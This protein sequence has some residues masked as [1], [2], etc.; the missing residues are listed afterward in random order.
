MEAGRV[1]VAYLRRSQ[2]PPDGQTDLSW[3]VQEAAVR[4]LATQFGDGEN[5]LLLFDW[6]RTGRQGAA[7]RR[8]G[9][10]R[11]LEMLRT[12]QVSAIYSYS[13]SRLS[14]GV[15]D[16]LDIV[17]LASEVGV[18]IRL[19][20]EGPMDPET[21]VGKVQINIMSAL[22]QFELDLAADRARDAAAA[23][24]RQGKPVGAP[25]YGYRVRNGEVVANGD[26]TNALRL[27][28]ET[29]RETGS[30]QATARRLT[31]LGVPTRRG[32][33]FWG[34]TA[35]RQIVRREAPGLVPVTVARG[36]AGVGSFRLTGLLRC[37][38]GTVLTGRRF[39]GRYVSYVCKRGVVDPAHGRPVSISEGRVLPQVEKAV[40]RLHIDPN[41]EADLK[42][43]EAQARKR[44]DA[45][46]DSMLDGVVPR[47]EYARRRPEFEAAI[48]RAKRAIA[49]TLIDAQPID[50]DAS[51]VNRYLRGVFEAFD[52]DESYRAVMPVF[53]APEFMGSDQAHQVPTD[54]EGA[55]T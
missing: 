20:K 3:P 41:L 10:Q 32:R 55:R 5:L 8:A 37:H 42:K 44:L 13:L 52:L 15:R 19:F 25:P 33:P 39:R 24:M 40:G 22:A 21:A 51:A 23:R 36:R 49:Q 9:Y 53:V 27:L 14:R 54:D 47:D 7:G 6:S 11:L 1:P 50:G 46:T 2:A 45:L 18:P 43:R 16:L 4:R 38:C 26:E 29:Y 48:D 28:L 31:E 17:E 30:F 34:A 12:G 35:I